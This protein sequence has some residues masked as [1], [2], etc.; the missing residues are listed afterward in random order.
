MTLPEPESRTEFFLARIAGQEVEIPIP[1]SRLELFLAYIAEHGSGGASFEARIVEQLP[2]TG[3]NGIIY[4]VPHQGGVAPNIYDEYLWIASSSSFETIGSTQIDLSDYVKN[5]DYAT[6]TKGGTIKVDPSYGTRVD[7]GFL[8]AGE[9]TYVQYTSGSG[10]MLIGKS[11][12]ENVFAGKK[13][14]STVVLSQ[15]EYDALTEYADNTEY[16]VY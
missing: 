12:L 11:T 9:R 2:E 3:E 4:L 13:V 5:T 10:N 14:V 15:V 7:N 6:T 16:L 8:R 1:E